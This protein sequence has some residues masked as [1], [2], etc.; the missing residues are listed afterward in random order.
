MKVV[1]ES[2]VKYSCKNPDSFL[3]L[4][5]TE[6]N[7]HKLSLQIVYY[8]DHGFKN[9]LFN[10]NL[11]N[12]EISVFKFIK[13]LKIKYLLKLTFEYNLHIAIKG[14][15]RC[16]FENNILT[17]NSRWNIFDNIIF[18]ES[19]DSENKSKI[20]ICQDCLYKAKCSGIPIT[21]I[22]KF[23]VIDF[24]PLLCNNKFHELNL[25]EIE[26]FKF[27]SMKNMAKK[28]LTDFS[29]CHSYKRKK[30]V[31]VKSLMSESVNSSQER[32]MYFIQN[33]K[34]DFEKNYIFLKQ[35]IS[36]EIIDL[37]YEYISMAS[38][39]ILSFSI[40][41][42]NDLRKSLSFNINH[43][44]KSQILKLSQITKC[45]INLENLADFAIYFRGDKVEYR[46]NY[47][48]K[49]ATVKDI[50]NFISDVNF[51]NKKNILKFSN[52]LT[53]AISN[54][55]FDYKYLN[56][57]LYSKRID[58]SLRE[59]S[60]RINQFNILFNINLNDFKHKEL[61]Q[62]SFEISNQS[63]E[64]IDLYYVLKL[65]ELIEEE[66]KYKQKSYYS[67]QRN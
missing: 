30:L 26:E 58:I 45:D 47:K 51:D 36:N 19:D 20:D 34:E 62:L 67:N 10:C 54:I 9:F 7:L 46:F 17:S 2:E 3:E 35:L 64:K 44:N 12:M 5:L 25:K 55:F 24:K 33:N 48:K 38:K 37:F 11:E 31:F 39:I 1:Q 52:S 18:V 6:K 40:M 63:S 57:E 13:K 41:E 8:T 16:I 22:N 50:K 60:F 14:I 43:L 28:V 49:L 32:F 4:N 23:D 61:H 27:E 56:N 29:D 42:N 59:N 15:P 21:Y 53:R 65:P 66:Y